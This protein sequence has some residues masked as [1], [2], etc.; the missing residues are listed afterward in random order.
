MMCSNKDT[1]HIGHQEDH[2]QND[3]FDENLSMLF[4]HGFWL[5]E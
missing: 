4:I 1:Q 2:Q 5:K 3:K